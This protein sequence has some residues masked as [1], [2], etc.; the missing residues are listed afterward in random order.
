MTLFRYP[1]DFNVS[2]PQQPKQR[3]ILPPNVKMVYSIIKAATGSIGGNADG[4]AIYGETTA[5]S[6]Q[7]IINLMKAHTNFTSDSRFIDLGSGL[8]KPNLHVAQDP[9]V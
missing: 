2:L 9:G 6:L 1:D 4:G 3:V 8:G 5:F 7:N